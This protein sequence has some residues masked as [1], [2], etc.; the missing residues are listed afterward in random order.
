MSLK[1]KPFLIAIGFTNFN[2]FFYTGW[3]AN[4]VKAEGEKHP[5][6]ATDT[7]LWVKQ[8]DIVLNTVNG[9]IGGLG[10]YLKTKAFGWCSA[11]LGV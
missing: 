2:F 11:G 1:R 9:P 10:G 4:P 3:Q 8:Y 6:N 5:Y 7:I